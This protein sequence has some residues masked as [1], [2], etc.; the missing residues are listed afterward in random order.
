QHGHF[1]PMLK[2][3]MSIQG[4]GSVLFLYNTI[5]AAHG[6]LA[7]IFH[8]FHGKKPI[9]PLPRFKG[10]SRGNIFYSRQKVFLDNFFLWP[11]D[12]DQDVFAGGTADKTFQES[13]KK[14]GQEKNA[15]WGNVRFSAA[16]KGDYTL[17]PDSAGWKIRIPDYLPGIRHAGACQEE[18][19]HALLGRNL[20]FTADAASLSTA[21]EELTFTVRAERET[22]YRVMTND[23]FYTVHPMSGTLKA[24]ECRK[25]TVRATAKDTPLSRIYRGVFFIRRPDGMS[26]PLSFAFDR[27]SNPVSGL[28][29]PNGGSVRIPRK[30]A[31]FV[32]LRGFALNGQH[33]LEINQ[34]KFKVRVAPY[35]RNKSEIIRLIDL[36]TQKLFRLPMEPGVYQFRMVRDPAFQLKTER[37]IISSE[38]DL[39][40]NGCL[41]HESK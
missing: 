38:P 2:N 7:C 27:R 33:V 5:A 10:I 32:F 34:R 23:R 21:A 18:D 24:G 19:I 35:L 6:G 13:M 1:G 29:I 3:G 8:N 39:I 26:L 11:A 28:E 15:L 31:Y 4:K 17:K 16:E 12:Y 40:Y 9:I 37:I 25:F 36:K 41:Q 22:P 20:G 14:N 30:D